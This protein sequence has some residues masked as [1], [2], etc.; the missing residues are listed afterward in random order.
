M[1]SAESDF[2]C[3]RGAV[4][5][6]ANGIS[7]ENGRRRPAVYTEGYL[8]SCCARGAALGASKGEISAS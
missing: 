6:V 1:R 2:G 4:E 5:T 7:T 8:A 3:P